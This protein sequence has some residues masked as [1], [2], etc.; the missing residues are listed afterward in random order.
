[1]K[2]CLQKINNIVKQ[3]RHLRTIESFEKIEA[4]IDS[5]AACCVCPRD[6][7]SD[8]PIR[9]RVESRR[10]VMF[11]TASGQQVAGESIKNNRV[12]H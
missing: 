7:C 10:G 2:T 1:M 5:V 3:R 9:Q 8:I 4:S 6:M 12:Q 11:R